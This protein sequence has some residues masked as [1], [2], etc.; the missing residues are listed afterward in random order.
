M[1]CKC[2][3]MLC[4]SERDAREQAALE[5]RLKGKD[6]EKNLARLRFYECDDEPGVWH[7]TRTK[8]WRTRA[9]YYEDEK[10]K[11]KCPGSGPKFIKRANAVR[12]RGELPEIEGMSMRVYQCPKSS[13][14]FH[15]EYFLDGL[16]N[17]C[18][19]CNR[20]IYSDYNAKRAMKILK[21]KGENKKRNA[22]KCK[23]GRLHVFD[24]V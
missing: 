10:G 22:G 20:V 21:K 4:A 23:Y 12:A 15:I 11:C 7:W 1:H 5:A 18:S 17:M 9:D 24:T 19:G 2:G 8:E 3:K 16:D 6:P 13:K 14:V